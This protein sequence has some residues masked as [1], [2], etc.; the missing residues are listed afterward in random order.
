[1]D[2]IHV[3]T[4]KMQLMVTGAEKACGCSL[5]VADQDGIWL[6][7]YEGY[8]VTRWNPENG[9]VREYDCYIQNSDKKLRSLRQAD[10][11][12]SFFSS[13]FCKTAPILLGLVAFVHGRIM[14]S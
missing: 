4:G 9:E 8:V 10:N 7:P 11:S 3:P 5:A 13:A 14:F 12:N 2:S 6:L 1:M